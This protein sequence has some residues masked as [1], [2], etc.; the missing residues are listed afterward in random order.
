MDQKFLALTIGSVAA[1]VVALT[2]AAQMHWPPEQG[3]SF[4]RPGVAASGIADHHERFKSRD[5]IVSF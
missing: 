3:G 5:D 2:I 4:G 1:L